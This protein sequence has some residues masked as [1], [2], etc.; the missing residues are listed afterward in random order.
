[1]ERSLEGPGRF[2]QVKAHRRMTETGEGNS[3][4]AGPGL[5]DSGA[6]RV[7]SIFFWL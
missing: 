2:R 4:E 7:I 3:S 5:V 6:L 1:M